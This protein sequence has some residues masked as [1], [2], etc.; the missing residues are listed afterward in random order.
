M[1]GN[2]RASH[3]CFPC[4]TGVYS[5]KNKIY[6]EHN[7]TMICLLLFQFILTS[8]TLSSVL[9]FGMIVSD[10]HLIYTVT[11][12]VM[13]SILLTRLLLSADLDLKH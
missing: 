13:T 1:H 11:V 9:C 5:F 6:Q 7:V 10:W 12:S 2:E 8:N 3:N 4:I